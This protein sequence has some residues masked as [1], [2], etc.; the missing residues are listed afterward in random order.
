MCARAVFSRLA[1]VRVV[2]HGQVA[3]VARAG[4]TG[5]VRGAASCRRCVYYRR[6]GVRRRAQCPWRMLSAAQVAWH[7]LAGLALSVASV[8]V[9][10][11]PLAA[12][13]GPMPLGANHAMLRTR[14]GR[15]V[16][17]A[18]LGAGGL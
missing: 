8:A 9:R 2:V 4:L 14:V 10:T 7:H 18:A 5:A 11:V 3:L 6:V 17:P 15:L 13:A 1:V 16:V 12:L